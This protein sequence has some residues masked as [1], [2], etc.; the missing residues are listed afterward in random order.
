MSASIA[1]WQGGFLLS[2]DNGQTWAVPYNQ[3]I[4][5]GDYVFHRI[6]SNVVLSVGNQYTGAPLDTTYV[7]WSNAS[8]NAPW[9]ESSPMGQ[10]SFT[11]LALDQT[12][13]TTLYVAG[14]LNSEGTQGIYKFS[15]TY[16]SSNQNIVSVSRVAGTFN[17]GLT[18]VSVRQLL[19]D[20]TKKYL[21]AATPSGIFRSGDQATT[22][23]SVSSSQ[24][25]N[26]SA[27][28]MAIT[29]DDKLL[30]GAGSGIWEYTD[31]SAQPGV[32]GLSPPAVSFG[33][34]SFDTPSPTLLATLTNT[35]SGT[36]TI[37]GVAL[38]GPNASDFSLPTDKCAPPTQLAPNTS[39]QVDVIFTPST[40]AS[41]SAI[42][43]FTDDTGGTPGSQQTVS[44]TGTGAQA[45]NTTGLTSSANP[46]LLGQAVT[47]T[48]SVTPQGSGTPAGTVT[49][50]DGQRP[51]VVRCLSLRGKLCARLRASP[52]GCTR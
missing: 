33:S 51:S 11:A 17:S 27:E 41:E 44:L 47:F 28:V 15:I 12:D 48:A 9:N 25:P 40:V 52:W 35:G 29:P 22:W 18:D 43:I 4:Y 16:D 32:A 34:Q 24:I 13:P 46:S 42:L 10:G 14:S 30:V 49:F 26:M 50:N 20:S 1:D 6:L 3:Y 19:Y 38:S 7:L 2:T 45:I 8:G 23:T 21:Y 5:P 39:C 36:L 37:T 31:T